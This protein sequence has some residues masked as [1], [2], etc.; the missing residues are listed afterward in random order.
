MLHR[1]KTLGLVALLGVA[2]F[3]AAAQGIRLVI[4]PTV[5]E[6]LKYSIKANLEVAGTEAV[7]NGTQVEKT[8][9]VDKDGGYTLESRLVDGK[10]EFAGQSMDIPPAPATVTVYKKDGSVKE[11][12]GDSVE[13]GAYRSANLT[14]AFFPDKDLKIGD[15][16]TN[17]QK[18]NS[19]SGAVAF[20]STFKLVADEK[21]N[22]IDSYKITSVTKES[23]GDTPA[24]AEGTTWLEKSTGRLVK[25]T[26]KLNNVPFPGAPGPINGTITI[27]RL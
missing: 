12:R 13:A 4:K 10:V 15:E 18:A 16:W 26:Q 3:A 20:K 8:I 6:E 7:L 21:V 2:A 1:T 17:E 14:S 22:G 25:S 9:D 27:T 5:G 19:S 24:S 11:I 23:E